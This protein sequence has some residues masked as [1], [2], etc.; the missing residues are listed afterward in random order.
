M[1]VRLDGSFLC[2]STFAVLAAGT[3]FPREV[4]DPSKFTAADYYDA[5]CECYA[6]IFAC[7]RTEWSRLESVWGFLGSSSSSV[8]W[9]AYSV[10]LMVVRAFAPTCCTDESDV[11]P[12]SVQ[13]MPS[14]N[15]CNSRDD[16]SGCTKRA[17]GEAAADACSANRGR[18]DFV[19]GRPFNERI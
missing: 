13:P 6:S 18:C 5:L 2:L 8:F 9:A 10:L 19:V 16:V 3:N 15:T 12:H 7:I 17:Y 14:H 11:I 1:H 4:Y